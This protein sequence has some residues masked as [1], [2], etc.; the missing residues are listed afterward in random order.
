MVKM[1]RVLKYKL[2]TSYEVGQANQ[3]IPDNEVLN[4]ATDNNLAVIT[5]NRDDFI[6]LHKSGFQH[7]GSIICKTD[8]DHQRQIN[9]LHEY[10]Q[11]QN[12]LSNRSIRI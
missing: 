5:F 1:L 4:Y 7:S 11:N 10:L 3:G 2:I 9:F 6:E 12:S 8:R